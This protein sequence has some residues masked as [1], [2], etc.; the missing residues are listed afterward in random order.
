LSQDILNTARNRLL[1]PN[2]PQEGIILAENIS[3]ES[4]VNFCETEPKLPVRI[5]LINGKVIAYE[6]LLGPHS[7]ASFQVCFLICNW[8]NEQLTGGCGEDLIVASNSYFTADATIRPIYLPPPLASQACNSIGWAYPN[9]VVEVGYIESIHSLHGLAPFYLSP[10][11]TIMIYLAI[12]LYSHHQD[13]TRAMVVMLYQRSSPTPN[14]PTKVISFGNEPLHNSVVD[15]FINTVGIPGT[16]ITGVGRHGAPPCN[17]P[18]LPTY[19]LPIP[20]AEIFH[21]TPTILPSVMFELD[22]WKVQRRVLR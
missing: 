2:P 9:V 16:L 20:A 11:T 21:R 8:D 22:L 18:N 10:H 19:Q 1:E 14:L 6:V 13:G 4:Y 12:K 5:R 15:F 3:F 17:A 7:S